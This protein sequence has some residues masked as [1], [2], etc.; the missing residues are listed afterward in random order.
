[1]P[2]DGT[3]EPHQLRNP[4]R[5]IAVALDR[6]RL[7]SIAHVLC[8]SSDRPALRRARRDVQMSLRGLLRG[9][10]LKGFMPPADRQA[11]L[12]F[13][14]RYAQNDCRGSA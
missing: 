14:S 9:F 3:A 7:E 6:H 13:P 2:Q 5:V 1:M 8:A 12:W 4:A 10:G 11:R